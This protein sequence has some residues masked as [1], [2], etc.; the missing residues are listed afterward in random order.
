MNGTLCF[1]SPNLIH[2]YTG[3]KMSFRSRVNRELDKINME[4]YIVV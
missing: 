3:Y 4:I 1:I 2:L